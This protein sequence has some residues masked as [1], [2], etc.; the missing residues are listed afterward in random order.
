M[1][2]RVSRDRLALRA[3]FLAGILMPHDASA[4]PDVLARLG[5]TG[6]IDARVVVADGEES[7]QN[8]GL[9][10]LRFDGNDLGRAQARV[11]IADA[12]LIAQPNF[13]DFRFH[14]DGRFQHSDRVSIGLNQAWIAWKPIPKGETKISARA[15]LFYPPISLEHDGP[16]WTTTRTLTP[17]AINSWIGEEVKVVGLEGKVSTPIGAH[18][19]TVAA[20]VFAA[21]DTTGILLTFRGWALHDV[22]VNAFDRLP[23]PRRSNQALDGL[24]S[25]T[26]PV[27]ELDN[28]PG[29]YVHGVWQ[30]PER[31][32]VNAT[33]FD[34]RGDPEAIEASREYGWRTKFINIGMRF[35]VDD[36]TQLMA[37]AMRGT[38]KMGHPDA[39]GRFPFDVTYRSAYLLGTRQMG[40]GRLTVRGDLFDVVDQTDVTIDNNNNETGWALTGAYMHPLSDRATV[41]VEIVHLSSNRPAR[42]LMA[43]SS[44]AGQDQFQLS[45]RYEF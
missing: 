21:N 1:R 10:K 22:G 6:S 14:I 15:G 17:S 33:W 4:E 39:D 41:R 20:G 11:A 31:L 8:D 9:G 32:S 23:L 7:W 36:K 40:K 34:N 38:T 45:L 28:R 18:E 3:M 37:Q 19:I 25:Y 12:H 44:K 42:T 16:G 13:G 2:K 29:Y 30:L 35:D 5:I 26:T 27:N 24:A 43:S